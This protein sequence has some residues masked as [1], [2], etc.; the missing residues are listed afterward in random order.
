M[1]HLNV[2][3]SFEFDRDNKLKSDFYGQSKKDSRHTLN[4]KSL[5]EPYQEKIWK[6]KARKAIKGCHVVVVLVGPDTHNAPGVIVETNMA[7][8]LK[9]P[10]IQVRRQGSTYQGL[11][12]IGKPIAWKWKVIDK[13]LDAVTAK[14]R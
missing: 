14:R 12:H 10:I 13:K 6:G 11:T 7:R 2:F 8:S 5:N 4:N 1:A 9:K 3:V